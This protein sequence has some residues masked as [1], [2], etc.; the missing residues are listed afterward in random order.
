MSRSLTDAKVPPAKLARAIERL[1][2]RLYRIN[3]RLVP[4]PAALIELIFGAWVAQA[5]QA[6]AKLGI[7]DALSEGPLPLA[8]L[9]RRVGADPTISAD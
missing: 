4:A 6:A 3:Q 9:A 1:R 5:I 7:A 8:D 2:H